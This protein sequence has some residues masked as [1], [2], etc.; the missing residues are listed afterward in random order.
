VVVAEAEGARI[1]NNKKPIMFKKPGI[2]SGR[3]R[4]WDPLLIQS[5]D[6]IS[7]ASYPEPQ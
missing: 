1:Y 4:K 2:W 5:L 3:M 7:P 6:R